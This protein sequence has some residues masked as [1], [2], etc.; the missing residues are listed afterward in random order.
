VKKIGG[1]TAV[2]VLLFCTSAQAQKYNWRKAI[3]PASFA[4]VSG[5]A[6]GFHE[7]SVHHPDRIPAGWNAN[8]WD[9][10]I[11]WKNKYYQNDPA[12]GAKYLGSTTFL[13][14]TTD[15]KHLFGSIH[16]VTLFGAG[17]SAGIVYTRGERRKWWHYA[18][19]AAITYAAYSIGFHAVYSGVF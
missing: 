13:A 17:A 10:R 2:F 19:D 9:N 6:Y 14:W 1:V 3:A 8:F 12:N 4:L 11:S 7:T 5:A 18:A 15:S 16:R